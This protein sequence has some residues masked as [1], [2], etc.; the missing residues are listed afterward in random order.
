MYDPMRVELLLDRV[1]A[2]QLPQAPV[3]GTVTWVRLRAWLHA[4]PGVGLVLRSSAYTPPAR[5]QVRGPVPA[6]G[7]CLV[8]A[9]RG[10]PGLRALARP[11]A[12]KRTT[13]MSPCGP[14]ATALM[15]HTVGVKVVEQLQRLTVETAV[16]LADAGSH[17]CPH[18]A[19]MELRRH[20]RD[21]RRTS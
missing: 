4:A 18:P 11:E 13:T 15:G 5:A 7:A 6:G 3:A 20:A 1:R 10:W 21:S 16:A 19:T 17:L 9:L 12:T 14:I 2:K 8:T